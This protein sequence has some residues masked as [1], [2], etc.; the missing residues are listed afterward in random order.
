[1]CQKVKILDDDKRIQIFERKI[2][3]GTSKHSVLKNKFVNINK[4]NL[5]SLALQLPSYKQEYKV[6]R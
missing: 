5:I 1:M 3:N 2:N 6:S 4:Q